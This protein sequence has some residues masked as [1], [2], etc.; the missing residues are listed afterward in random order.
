MFCSSNSGYSFTDFIDLVAG[1]TGY[2]AVERQSPCPH[3]AYILMWRE[4]EI[5]SE[6]HS[7]P[8]GGQYY[9]TEKAGKGGWEVPCSNL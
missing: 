5:T 4:K 8:G 2:S 1:G 3:R 7:M 6:L 9:R